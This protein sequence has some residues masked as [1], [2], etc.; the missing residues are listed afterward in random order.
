MTLA[1]VP[2]FAWASLVGAAALVVA[3]PVLIGNLVLLTVDHRYGARRVRRQRT[4]IARLDGWALT[5]PATYVVRHPGARHRRRCRRHGDLASPAHRSRP[6][7]LVGIGLFAT[8]V[9]AAVTQRC[10][11]CHG[12]AASAPTSVTRSTTCCRTCCSTCC[13][14]SGRWSSLGACSL[15]L[16]PAKPQHLPAAARVRL[17]RGRDADS[18]CRRPR[19]D[20]RRRPRSS[21][22]PSYEEGVFVYVLVRRRAGRPRRHGLLG[23]EAV[24]ADAARRVGA[25]A[26]PARVRSARG[27]WRRCRCSS[28]G[29]RAS[30]PMTVGG[31]DYDLAPELLNTLVLVGHGLLLLTRRSPWPCSPCRASPAVRRRRRPVGRPDARMGDLVAAAGR[32]LRRGPHGLLGRSRCSTSSPPGVT[33]D[34]RLARCPGPAPRRQVLAGTALFGA[35]AAMLIGGHARRLVAVPRT[36]PR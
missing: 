34:A 15:A 17:P 14:S 12:P 5:Q 25:P 31:F 26:R 29:S 9:L 13:R 32:Q 1:R 30:R 20:R 24:G 36:P 7:L 18:R 4:A 10:T 23:S 21:S 3:V 33:P 22:A 6:A 28:P 8:A 19:P 27:R 35:A 11:R 2:L 16:T